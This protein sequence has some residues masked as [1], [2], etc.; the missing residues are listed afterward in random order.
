MPLNYPQYDDL[1]SQIIAEYRRQ[2]PQ[3]DPTVE[4]SWSGAFMKGTAALAQ[5]VLLVIRDLEIQLFPQT[6]TDEF[7]DLWGG[8]EGLERLTATQAS[9]PIA[10]TGTAGTIIPAG[11]LLSSAT[12]LQYETLTSA[13]IE[14]GIDTLES[15]TRQGSIAT[16]TTSA[17]HNLATGQS[18][19]ISGADQNDYNGTFSIT[20]TS[21]TEFQYT[22][23]G[24]PTTPATGFIGYSVTF[25]SVEVLSL[26]TGSDTNLSNGATLNFVSEITGADTTALVAFGGV[27]GGTDDEDEE[28]YRARILLSRRSQAGVFTEDQIKLAALGVAGNTRAFVIKPTATVCDAGTGFAGMLPIPGQVA[29]YILRDDDPDIIPSPAILATTKQAIID[30]GKLPAHTSEVDVFVLAPDTVIVNFDF[31]AMDPDTTTM[32]TAVENQIRAFFADSVDFETDV[33]EASY[34][35]AIQSTQD[36]QTGEFIKSF[37]LTNPLG[38]VTVGDGE[39]AIAGTVVFNF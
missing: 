29:V 1:V 39:I 14:T 15:L 26:D 2:L 34:L 21:E 31:L 11:T 8:Y 3:V 28:S 27:T 6:A 12:G 33:T 10:I 36:L 9:G 37:T 24:S 25:A 23:T 18:V 5:T 38:D 35:G 7:L 30:N 22:V 4:G 17:S 13:S 19:T 20:V 32:R 16:A